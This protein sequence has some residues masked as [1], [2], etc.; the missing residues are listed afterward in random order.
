MHPE[1]AGHGTARHGEHATARRGNLLACGA[2]RTAR[3]GTRHRSDVHA[4]C[5]FR[6]RGWLFR[7]MIKD[8]PRWSSPKETCTRPSDARR[9][10]R[11]G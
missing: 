8:A 1:E 2:L 11:H 5:L 3:H 9:T 7:P 6:F 10:A 4:L